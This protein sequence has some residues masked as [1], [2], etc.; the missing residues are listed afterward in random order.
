V[1]RVPRSRLGELEPLWAALYEHQ[2][3][4][5]PQLQDRRRTLEES[6]RDRRAKEERWITAEPRTFVLAAEVDSMLVGYAF[7]R[8][9]EA[10]LAVSWEFADPHAELATLSVMPDYRGQ[11]VGGA[12][13]SGVYAELRA[14]GI[15]DLT[16]GVIAT[17]TR[18]ARF[19]ERLGA[20]PFLTTYVQR[21]P[22][23]A[24]PVSADVVNRLELKLLSEPFAIARLG[25]GEPVPGWATASAQLVSVVRSDDELSVVAPERLVPAGIQAER[26]WQ[27]LKVTGPLSFDL[28][29][30]LA[31]LTRAL[32][33]AG[34]TVFVISTY[35]TDFLLVR[36]E[37]ISGAIEALRSAGHT[38]LIQADGS[39]LPVARA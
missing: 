4:T 21:V 14:L 39:S 29:G 34:A 37:A 7:V 27:A 11:S 22:E 23:A 36:A 24:T 2:Q 19:Y 5:A 33:E 8:V 17:N 10:P 6:W 9:I 3:L 1:V 31:G 18:A 30:V 15:A 13:M 32:A 38:V 25:R 20:V 28:V 35:D 26:S 12:L 16:I